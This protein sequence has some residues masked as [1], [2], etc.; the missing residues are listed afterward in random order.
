MDDRDDVFTIGQL[1][2]RT[3]LSTRTIRFYADTGVVPP[4]GRSP[5]GHR[6]YDTGA[7]ARLEL[8]RTLRELGVGLPDI[9]R[10]LERETTVPELAELHAAALDTQIRTLRLRRSV[11]RAVARL[12]ATTKE[13]GTMHKLAKLSAEERQRLLEEFWD[14]TFGGLDIDPSFAEKVRGVRPDLPDD[15]T[16]E[17]VAAWVELAELV[18]DPG[19]RARVRAMSEAHAAARTAGTPM[20]A[21]GLAEREAM[22]AVV[23]R[24]GQAL[25]AG[26]DPASAEA[27]PIAD[28]IA[29]RVAA[30]P[31]QAA[32]PGFRRTTAD[33]WAVGTD[34]RV[35][36]YWQLVGTL[37]GWGRMPSTVPAHE[38]A[39]AALRASAD[40]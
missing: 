13:L 38:W 15:P 27:R 29:A 6:V 19:Y 25:A 33:Q 4:T 12:G 40:A 22:A 31:A 1:A 23:E 3:G 26:I 39:I 5:A 10:V 32:D 11:L 24:A 18:S 34:A 14:E 9:R 8:V 36:R 21:P 37:N 16:P 17:Q 7:V 30:D 20:G 35:E 28:E 2:R